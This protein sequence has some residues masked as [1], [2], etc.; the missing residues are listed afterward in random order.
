MVVVSSKDDN[1]VPYYSSRVDSNPGQYTGDERI[2]KMSENMLKRLKK[3][4][5]MEVWFDVEHDINTFDKITGRRAHI[6]FLE[7]RVFLDIFFRLY[8]NQL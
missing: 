5:R 8:A 4:E 6:E 1:F 2:M 7:N 3:I